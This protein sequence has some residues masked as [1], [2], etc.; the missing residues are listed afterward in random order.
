LSKRYLQQ[1]TVFL[2]NVLS[3]RDGQARWCDD[4]TTPAVETCAEMKTRALELALADLKKRL[5]PDRAKW[6]WDALHFVRAVHRPFSN[7]PQIARFFE[8]D[9]PI[10]GDSNTVDVA[11]YSIEDDDAPFVD[12]HGPSLREIIDF[13]DLENSRFIQ[14]TGQSGNRLSPFYANLFDRWRA[15][16][17]VPMQMQ[18]ETVE[19]GAVG[20]LRLTP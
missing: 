7:V 16:G 19:K 9:A 3:D 14:S 6:R 12:R 20:T 8:L 11:G 18:R 15:V 10:S 5:G 1:R 4:I 13:G 17:S 2:I